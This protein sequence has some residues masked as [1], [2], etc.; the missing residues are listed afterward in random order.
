MP[1]PPGRHAPGPG[2]RCSG[3]TCSAASPCSGATRTGL[4]AAPGD[5]AARSGAAC[6]SRY[7][8]STRPACWLAAVG[9]F[10]FSF[11]VFF[12]LDPERRVSVGRFGFGALPPA[13]RADPDSLRAVAAAHLRDARGAERRA[14]ARDPRRCSRWSGSARSASSLRS[15]SRAPRRLPVARA[16]ALA[17]ALAFSFQTALLD[18]LVWPAYFPR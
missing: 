1:N 3:S 9:Y 14:L 6:R 8:R 5:A 17:G 2:A 4:G 11:F 10:A 18:A 12:R 7:A 13:L 15:P 16:V